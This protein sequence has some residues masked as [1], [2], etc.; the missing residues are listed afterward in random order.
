MQIQVS[1]RA[2]TL[3]IV[4]LL[5]LS[6]ITVGAVAWTLTR[7]D[8]ASARPAAKRAVATTPATGASVPVRMWAK[9]A[10]TQ[11][12]AGSPA[13][14]Q[15]IADV[16]ESALPS[17]VNITTE[18]AG[19]RGPLL[20]GRGRRSLPFPFGPRG[21]R[22]G[23]MLRGQGSGVIVSSDGVVL[24]NNHVVRGARS[25]RVTLADRREVEAKLVGADP[26][27]DLAVLRLKGSPG[28]LKPIPFG[29]SDKMRLGSVVLA[30]GN[31]F[32]VG[33]TVTMGIVSAKGRANVGIVDYED[34]IQTDAAINPGNSGGA[35]VDMQGRLVGINTAILSRS[36]G[37]QGIG[38][39]IP[40]RMA[41]HVMG[42]LL[43]Y[44]KVRRGFLGVRIQ[45]VTPTLSG[46]LGLG[47]QRGVL[48]ADVEPGSA[49]ARAG[50]KAKDV[51]LRV[52]G[53][54]VDTSGRLRSIIANRPPGARVKL[55]LLRG[56]KPRTVQVTLGALGG[57]PVASKPPGRATP[58]A[59]PQVAPRP[60][61]KVGPKVG[62]KAAPGAAP[63]AGAPSPRSSAA[64]APP[65]GSRSLHGLTISPVT[66]ALR[67]HYRVPYAFSKNV[68]ITAVAPGSEGAR[69]GLQPGDAVLSVDRR[70][71]FSVKRFV[72]YTRIGGSHV[73]LEVYRNGDTHTFALRKSG[74]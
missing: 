17:V 10:L 44:G 38:F 72:V 19:G 62:S 68:V 71:V 3:T 39:A 55:R 26:K 28:N 8:G 12:T 2:A 73:V 66:R 69:A 7:A 37:Y 42:S 35:L 52:D 23:P 14:P 30:I 1:R 65:P 49:A 41:K 5:T 46:K 64:P 33:Q 21:R 29:D 51:V 50:L 4:A 36:G 16:T 9:P 27:S 24:T 67:K 45:T 61:P 22:G 70:D 74:K 18:K 31:P 56:R 13:G 40:T 59:A 34:F 32:G 60:A 43:R 11:A 25:I 15:S 57:G 63:Q 6:M 54:T 47:T 20:R 53:I 58:G 48:I